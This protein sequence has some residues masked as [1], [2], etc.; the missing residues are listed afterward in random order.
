M[1]NLNDHKLKLDY[2]CSWEYRLVI[3]Q[4]INIKIILDETLGQ[5][6]HKVNIS[7]KS[8]N[9]KFTSHKVQLLVHNDDD[10]EE[11]HKIFHAHKDVKMI[12]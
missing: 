10:R 9:G 4:E 6:D 8:S 7:N 12:V 3:K 1:V 11:L 5:R 2:P